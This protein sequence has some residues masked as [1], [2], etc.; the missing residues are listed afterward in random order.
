M[1]QLKSPRQEAFC[2]Y[3]A[4][5]AT[6]S[7]SYERAGFAGSRSNAPRLSKAGHIIE[8]RDE[9][10]AELK[11]ARPPEKPV[12]EMTGLE[13]MDKAAAMAIDA[14]NAVTLAAV[15]KTKAEHDASIKSLTPDIGKLSDDD[16]T[17]ELLPFA[18][19]VLA[20]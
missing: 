18:R 5:G 20:Q 15:G 17:A 8:R 14:N 9:I 19:S 7:A 13:L 11:A 1:G 6:I 12:S 4:E 2:R 3:W 16:L 10:R